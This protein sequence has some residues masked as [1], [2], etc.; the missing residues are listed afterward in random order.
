[1]DKKIKIYHIDWND[2]L[3]LD[4]E[5]NIIKR[6]Y[7]NDYG[8]FILIDNF[9]LIIWEKWGKEYFYSKDNN[10]YY[11]INDNNTFNLDNDVSIIYLI[12]ISN[13]IKIVNFLKTNNFI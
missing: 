5:R 8:K 3:Y 9:L 1:M 4:Y 6:L 12:D 10:N 11:F 7:N 13:S 2:D